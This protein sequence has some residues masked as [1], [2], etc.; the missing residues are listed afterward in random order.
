MRFIRTPISAAIAS[1]ALLAGVFPAVAESDRFAQQTAPG[2]ETQGPNLAPQVDEID[3]NQTQQSAPVDTTQDAND[4]PQSRGLTQDQ[5]QQPSTS[6]VETQGPNLAPRTDEIGDNQT[7][8]QQSAPAVE[9]QGVD[10][11]PQ[12]GE[13]ALDQ[14]QPQ[15]MQPQAERDRSFPRLEIRGPNFA[16]HIV[17]D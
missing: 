9:T 5:Y 12:A 7:Q 6:G 14:T 4:V 13:P 8:S 17:H 16:P 1:L 11:T 2:V 10:N 15:A 3:Q